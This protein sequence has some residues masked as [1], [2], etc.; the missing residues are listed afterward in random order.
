MNIGNFRQPATLH[1]C[2]SRRPANIMI[3]S[4]FFLRPFTSLGF[5][6]HFQA[7]TGFDLWKFFTVGASAYDIL[8]SGRATRAAAARAR[9]TDVF[10]RTTR[11]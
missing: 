3:D 9:L 1:H 2:S 4:R 6:A 11:R 7:G 10:L 5:N 8:P